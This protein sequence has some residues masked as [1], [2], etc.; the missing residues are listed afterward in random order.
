MPDPS[1]S[2][3]TVSESTVSESTASEST[4][5][6]STASRPPSAAPRGR[7]PWPPPRCPTSVPERRKF[8]RDEARPVKRQ[9]SF[10]LPWADWRRLRAE[11]DRTGGTVTA[12]CR[13]A[14]APLLA[15]L[16]RGEPASRDPWVTDPPDRG[17]V[18][19]DRPAP[20][21]RTGGFSR[22]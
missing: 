22:P 19:P 16:S 12:L 1:V 14:L 20:A 3:S 2:E 5:S 17:R 13:D 21:G 9:V 4:A 11:A 6:E 7:D 15:R 8:E 18:A 10:F